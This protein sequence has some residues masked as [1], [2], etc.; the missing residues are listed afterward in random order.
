MVD[1]ADR[2]RI[3][4]SWQIAAEL[5][6]RHPHL[7]VHE[8]HPGGGMYDCLGLFVD[9][10]PGAVIDLNRAGSLH[11]HRP[12]KGAVA[13][14]ADV[15]AGGTHAIVKALEMT[16][17]L[18][19][20]PMTTP[21]SLTYRVLAQLLAARVG[22]RHT[23]DARSVFYD[24]SGDDA[25]LGLRDAWLDDFTSARAA[26]PRL[27]R[28]GWAGEPE[29]HLWALTR[30]EEPVLVVDVHGTAHTRTGR[31]VDLWGRYKATGRHLHRTVAGTVTA[32]IP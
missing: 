21:R 5:A 32:V 28:H 22:D 23:W 4:W 31:A 20:A 11:V 13:T 15:A 26:L 3:V 17:G 2:F 14:W 12:P 19:P 27:P 1:V 7:R 8:Y 18:H 10:A 25:D 9:G 29:S 24:S 6:R 30:S 16:A